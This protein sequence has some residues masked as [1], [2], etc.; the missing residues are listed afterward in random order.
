[1]PRLFL[2]LAFLVLPRALMTQNGNT[3]AAPDIGTWQAPAGSRRYVAVEGTANPW[4]FDLVITGGRVTGE[5]RQRPANPAVTE[6]PGPFQVL[7]GTA[8]GDTIAFTIE[9][10]GGDRVVRFRGLRI[11]DRIDFNRSVEVVRGAAGGNGIVGT[12]GATIFSARLVAPGQSIPTR[13]A[14][15]QESVTKPLTGPRQTVVHRGFTIDVTEVTS[16]A[17]Y[18]SVITA[19]KGQLDLVANAKMPAAAHAFFRTVPIVMQDITGRPRYGAG[20]VVI[21]LRS[22]APYGSDRPIVL[23]ELCHAYHDLK[24]ADGFSN[25]TILGFYEQAK[26]SGKFPGDSYMLS[27]VPEYFAMMA[28]VFLHGSAARDPFV[29]D[30][31]RAKQPAMY[32]WLVKEFGQPAA[33]P[34]TRNR[35]LAFVVSRNG[36]PKGSAL[37]PVGQPHQRELEGGADFRSKQGPG[38]AGIQPRSWAL[39]V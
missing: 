13:G 19:M 20:R 37:E 36:A 31:I 32:D 34:S 14:L 4:I 1:M 12:N 16:A 18:A 2:I 3:P 38:R 30:S 33:P 35:G 9:S 8:R 7:N 10:N 29:R 11:G 25:S 28:S 21:P 5:A 24:L 6:A 17:D 39:F 23:H 27:T 15:A 26:Q 22:E